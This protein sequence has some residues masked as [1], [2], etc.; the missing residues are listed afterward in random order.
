MEG[1]GERVPLTSIKHMLVDY[2]AMS[3]LRCTKNSLD[4]M[5]TGKY[6]GISLSDAAAMLT[7]LLACYLLLLLNC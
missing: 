3:L 5:V 4:V 7:G 1:S 2:A 6:V